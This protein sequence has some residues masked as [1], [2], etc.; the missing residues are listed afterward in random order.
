MR[1]PTALREPGRVQAWVC[2]AVGYDSENKLLGVHLYTTMKRI[3]EMQ[4]VVIV[5]GAGRSFVGLRKRPGKG[6]RR[7]R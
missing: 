6:R 3:M 7:G 1:N 5:N 4:T 2:E